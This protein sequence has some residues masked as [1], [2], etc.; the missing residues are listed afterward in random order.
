M[1]TYFKP[2]TMNI[3]LTTIC[4]L[5]CPQCYC[6]LEGNKNI[7][8]EK[9]IHWLKQAGELG[10]HSVF[11]SGGETMCY[12]YIYEVVSAA[13]LYCGNLYVALSGYGFTDEVLEKLVSAGISGI[14]ISLN[15]S[16]EEINALTRDGYE[17]AISTLSLL[18]EKQYTETWL[19]WVMHSNNTND[20]ENILSL[21]ESYNIKNL[22]VMALKPDSNYKLETAPSAEVMR[23]FAKRIRRYRGNV[24]IMVEPCFSPML[25][26]VF[27]DKWFGNTNTG[28]DKGCG[29]GITSFSVNVDGMLS[30][31]RH[32]DYFE[33]YESLYEY[34]HHSTI[35]RKLRTLEYVK[36]PPCNACYYS[37]YCRHCVAVNSK[38]KGEL[39]LGNAACEL[40]LMA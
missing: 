21:A 7:N 3:E 18:K 29:A 16:T 24:Q 35:L 10:V 19:N 9:A 33:S 1:S 2:V 12:P 34:W 27:D 8:R 31:C 22:V 14:C 39:Y 11:L 13:S 5:K 23:E 15:G 30:P 36:K 6:K 32:L 17:L 28:A 26:L 25:A 37:P 38:L 20:F 40:H 4:P